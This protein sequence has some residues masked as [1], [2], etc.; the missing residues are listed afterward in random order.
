M[1]SHS[2]SLEQPDAGRETV[3]LPL[4]R[5]TRFCQRSSPTPTPSNDL[6]LAE[7][8]SHSNSLEQPDSGREAVPLPLPRTSRFWQRKQNISEQVQ[9]HLLSRRHHHACF[10]HCF[11]AVGCTTDCCPHPARASTSP[12]GVLHHRTR[13]QP[14]LHHPLAPGNPRGPSVLRQNSQ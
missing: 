6:I 13:P 5:T 2:H 3:P 11:A 14:P 8:Q 12:K 1:K 9:L 4:P 7:K 10:V